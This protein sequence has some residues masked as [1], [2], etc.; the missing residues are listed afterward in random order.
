M[1]NHKKHFN[2]G[3]AGVQAIVLLAIVTIVLFFT[4]NFHIPN[5]GQ[6]TGYVSSVEQSGIIW[7][8]WTAYIKTD[9]QSS[10]ED[11]YCVTDP[12]TVITLQS[13]ETEKSSVTVNYSVP[14]MTWKWQCGYEQ[15]TIQSVSRSSDIKAFEDS[16]Q[17]F[18]T[19][20]GN[21]WVPILASIID[22]R[23]PDGTT[24][25]LKQYNDDFSEITKTN[26]S[27]T[28]LS[29]AQH[30][31]PIAQSYESSLEQNVN[32]EVIAIQTASELNTKAASIKNSQLRTEAL[33]ITDSVNRQMKALTDYRLAIQN[34]ITL[35]IKLFEDIVNENGGTNSF[36]SDLI[37]SSPK[38]DNQIIDSFDHSTSL[39]DL[40][41]AFARF[42]GL[43]QSQ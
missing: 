6:H 7:K 8:T 42:Q 32:L 22:G 28:R 33:S 24:T 35:V 2:S 43:A 25:G 19:A 21:A 16:Y 37:S 9:P 11:T 14:W 41:T 5:S 12:K 17:D 36:N 34:K 1:I 27:S 31:L 20:Y 29:L 3:E 18:I 30:G 4:A 39:N 13:A 23:L 10:Q 38:A 15:S 40:Q 26:N